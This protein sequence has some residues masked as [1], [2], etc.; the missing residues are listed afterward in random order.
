M[1]GRPVNSTGASPFH[2]LS[3]IVYPPLRRKTKKQQ[4]RQFAAA[5]GL[6]GLLRRIHVDH[7]VL[8]LRELGL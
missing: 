1:L 7:T 2:L 4:P 8:H 5:V 6:S 3:I